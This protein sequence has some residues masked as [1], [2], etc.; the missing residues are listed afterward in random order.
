V[1]SQPFIVQLPR[2]PAPST[3]L[4]DVIVGSLTLTGL[5]VVVAVLLGGVTAILLV[6]WRR[7]HPPEL[8]RLPPISPLV[9]GPDSRQ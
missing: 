3:S 4:V 7:R 9:P 6:R 2:E 1:Q 5:I 8:D